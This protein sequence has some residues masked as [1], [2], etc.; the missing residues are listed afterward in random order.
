MTGSPNSAICVDASP[1]YLKLFYNVNAATSGMMLGGYQPF[2]SFNSGVTVFNSTVSNVIYLTTGWFVYLSGSS[3]YAAQ[4]APPYVTYTSTSAYQINA[5][6][7][8]G[9]GQLQSSAAAAPWRDNQTYP[10]GNNVVLLWDPSTL[11]ITCVSTPASASSWAGYTSPGFSGLP[12]NLMYTNY[13]PQSS[14]GKYYIA[15]LE[16]PAFPAINCNTSLWASNDLLNWSKVS[17][18]CKG[19]TACTIDFPYGGFRVTGQVP[20]MGGTVTVTYISPDGLTWY[21]VA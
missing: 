13:V 19:L 8:V 20:Y 10:L 1:S 21:L 14:N 3:W 6:Y 18:I 7:L 5:P 16:A 2:S 12:Q 9:S 15:L 4:I 11:K 17:V